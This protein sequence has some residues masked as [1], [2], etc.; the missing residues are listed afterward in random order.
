MALQYHYTRADLIQALRTVG[1]GRGDTVY[2]HVSTG[3]LGLPEGGDSTEYACQLLYDAI[4]EV[5]GV[6]G[7]LLVPTYTLS[8]GR[9]EL[10]D[11]QNTPGTTGP[12]TEL[13]RS[14]PGAIRS[15]NPMS[16]VAGIGPKAGYFL[17]DLPHTTYGVGSVFDRMRHH[18]VKICNIGVTLYWATFLHH[19]EEMVMV[20]YRFKKLF[21]GWIRDN[22]ELRYEHWKY[23]AAILVH[24]CL[25][26]GRPIDRIVRESVICRA[27]PLGRGEILCLRSDEY[28]KLACE[29]FRKNAWLTANG[30]PLTPDTIV[31]LEDKR[32]GHAPL[33][34]DIAPD[35]PVIELIRHLAPLPVFALSAAYDAC[36]DTL[37]QR[38]KFSTGSYPTGTECYDWLVPEKWTFRSASIEAEDGSTKLQCNPSTPLIAAHSQPFN[39]S[40]KYADLIEHATTCED[41]RRTPYREMMYTRDWGLCISRSA[42]QTLKEGTYNFRIDSDFSYGLLRSGEAVLQGRTA[43][44][45]LFCA[46]MD[47]PG[48]VNLGLSSALAVVDMFRELSLAPMP[49]VTCRFLIYGGTAG[50]LSYMKTREA[51]AGR[52]LIVKLES[53][54]LEY[55]LVLRHKNAID[56]AHNWVDAVVRSASVVVQECDSIF[57]QGSYPFPLP[58]FGHS[59]CS[60]S[61]NP[62]DGFFAERLTDQDGEHLFSLPQYEDT[63]KTLAGAV[64]SLGEASKR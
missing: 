6:E 5:L 10:Y 25:A 4:R 53:P 62:T 9:R 15:G 28:F 36:I 64:C 27:Q 17:S 51:S 8:V 13:V 60:I 33:R 55:G 22:G 43:D 19:I 50:F 11:V 20:P 58:T 47:L 41:P 29:E 46:Q 34:L 54:G 39:G 14:M 45:I 37:I 23:Y 57:D 7:T 48:Q 63:I 35:S 3:R 49:L 21:S 52:G 18:G 2:T 61:R 44:W 56:F 16:S 26:D 1:L 12:F 24:N 38:G 42:I 31:E 30:P 59:I 40:V 32:V